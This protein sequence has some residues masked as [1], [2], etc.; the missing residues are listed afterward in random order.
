MDYLCG[1]VMVVGMVEMFGAAHVK[2]IEGP[3]E[4]RARGHRRRPILFS[5][6]L[7][8]VRTSLVIIVNH[9]YCHFL[10]YSWIDHECNA[11]I[12]RARIYMHL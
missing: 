2:R 5:S 12:S 8:Y 6:A 7:K 11:V 1:M 9:H 4:G 3:E 10:R